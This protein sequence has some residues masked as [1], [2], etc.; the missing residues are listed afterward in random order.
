MGEVNEEA[1]MFGCVKM[2]EGHIDF[3]LHEAMGILSSLSL[4]SITLGNFLVV[5]RSDFDVIIA[6]EPYIG[7]QLLLNLRTGR[8]LSRIWNQTVARGDIVTAQQLTDICN[9]LFDQG[10]PCLGCPE[11][12][13]DASEKQD[14]LI[15]H[16]PIP[17]KIART[18][19]KVMGK[20]TSPSVSTCREC[21]KISDNGNGQDQDSTIKMAK[22]KGKLEL[23]SPTVSDEDSDWEGLDY[24]IKS[25]Y[26][27]AESFNVGDAMLED[28]DDEDSTPRG[29]EHVE[30]HHLKTEAEDYKHKETDETPM[31]DTPLI[32]CEHQ[33]CHREFKKIGN[34]KQHLKARHSD[35]AQLPKPKKQMQHDSDKPSFQLDQLIAEALTWAR[36]SWLTRSDICWYITRK[37][38]TYKIE[39]KDWQ[40]QVTINLIRKD[41]F[42]R[43]PNQEGGK[44]SCWK[45]RKGHETRIPEV[46][47]CITC[48]ERFGDENS[49]KY[50]MVQLNHQEQNSGDGMKASKLECLE[51]NEDTDQNRQEYVMRQRLKLAKENEPDHDFLVG[52]GTFHGKIKP[53]LKKG[54]YYECSKC[55]FKTQS[56]KMMKHIRN[57][58]FWGDFS[59]L[60]CGFKAKYV[61]DLLE[62]MEQNNHVNDPFVQCPFCKER[63]AINEVKV[64]YKRCL[65]KDKSEKTVC[66]ICG[67]QMRKDKMKDHK[68]VH[69]REQGVIENE[70]TLYCD[71]CGKK[72]STA[73]NLA[74]HKKNIHNP[75]PRPCSACGLVF[76]NYPKL[77]KHYDNEHNPKQCEHCDYKTGSN[78]Q[79][80]LHMAKHFD[81]KF[82]CS[83]CEK[84]YKSQ[85]SLEA[86]ERDHTGERPFECPACGKGFKSNSV[87]IT[88]KKHVHKILTPG[89]TPIEKR[90]RKK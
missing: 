27:S 73:H 52:R 10:R 57:Q 66:S 28:M 88:H 6:E 20:D 36:D 65:N 61:D 39:G 48:G 38:P 30:Q 21:L 69:L 26:L 84:M 62:H 79:L 85:K 31:N 2:E 54:N 15:S 67:K 82:K 11:D 77:R 68:K 70:S 53:W 29:I 47:S 76:P 72:A 22:G 58:H 33:D 19:L 4:T 51:N 89:M 8:Y 7:I 63:V 42:E 46:L 87:L 81:P 37:Y 90:A 71:I 45:I 32:K 35:S 3:S 34:Y 12:T 1:P 25:E 49:L 80:K 75:V 50:H 40:K 74:T 41:V 5:N 55:P 78:A 16:T 24:A 9:N 13:R 64:H 83:Y 43:V 23:I 60:Q 44:P 86:H 56:S 18:C 17:R 14:F 59:C